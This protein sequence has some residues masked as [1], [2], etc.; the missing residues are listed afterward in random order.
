MLICQP[1]FT[2]R[3]TLVTIY[4]WTTYQ[5]RKVFIAN[6]EKEH[7]VFFMSRYLIIPNGRACA[8]PWM[9]NLICFDAQVG[10]CFSGEKNDAYSL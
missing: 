9:N 6:Q 1:S 7:I 4:D 2:V 3:L 10:L 8:V 5:R